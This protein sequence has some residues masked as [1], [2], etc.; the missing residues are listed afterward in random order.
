MNE[1]QKSPIEQ[2][3]YGFISPR[4][5]PKGKDEYY[6]RNLQNTKCNCVSAAVSLGKEGVDSQ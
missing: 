6:L 4:Y 2:L 3:G 5:I 1:I